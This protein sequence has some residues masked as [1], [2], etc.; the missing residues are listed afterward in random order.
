[1]Q[2]QGTQPCALMSLAVPALMSRA[3]MLVEVLTGN[4]PAVALSPGRRAPGHYP[5]GSARPFDIPLSVPRLD[6]RSPDDER[7]QHAAF[8]SLFPLNNGVV[9]LSVLNPV[10]SS[11]GK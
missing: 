4:L 1:M 2:V 3:L 9:I 7:V 8:S 6:V 5:P 11:P 10:V